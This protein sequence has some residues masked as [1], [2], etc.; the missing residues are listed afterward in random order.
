MKNKQKTVLIP[1]MLD[2]HFPL[3]Q[4]AFCSKKYNAVILGDMENIVETGL[5]YAH[6]DLC[7]PCVLIIGQM[8]NALKSE[9]Y[10][11][12]NTILL[13]PQAG[14]ACRGSNYIHMIR[15]ALKKAGYSDIPIISL[16]FKGLEG[17]NQ[18]SVNPLMVMKAVAAI[19][20]SDI[21]MILKNQIKPYENNIGETKKYVDKWTNIL[22]NQIKSGKKLSYILIKRNLKRISEEFKNI[23][24]I[25][26]CTNKIGIVGELYIKYCKLGNSN[27]ENYLRE[28]NCEYMVNGFSWYILY[29]IDTHLTE[30]SKAM[31][32]LFRIALKYLSGLQKSVVMNLRN[33]GFR[34]ISEYKSFKNEAKGKVSFGL[35]VADGWLISCEVINLIKEGYN[36]ILCVQPFGCMPNHICGKGMYANLQRQFPDV[37]IVSVDYDS[38]GSEIN[39][40]NRIK[41]LIDI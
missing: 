37:N 23:K 31:G 4:Y 36:K 33:N 28:E 19:M 3:L 13:I 27:L 24:Q 38:S 34:C 30:E 8:I 39:I 2:F 14:D 15:N 40:H 35:K 29:Y 12:K 5:F 6:N 17:E 10:D 16:N 22:E 32:L 25:E 7:Y 9:K 20:Y 1:S 18:F 11:L 26:K 41:M 21:L